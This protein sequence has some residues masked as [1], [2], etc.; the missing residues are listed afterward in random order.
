MK[1]MGTMN[2]I[3]LEK[4]RL[5]AEILNNRSTIPPEKIEEDSRIIMSKLFA[6]PAYTQS[7]TIMCFIDLKK[8]VIT[9]DFIRRSMDNGKRV[10]VPIIV[11]EES[12]GRSMRAS[13]LLDFEDDLES[14]TMGILEPKPDKRRYADPAEIDFIV[15]PGLAFDI[16]R[17][18]LGYGAGFYDAYLKKIRPDCETVAVCFDY[19]V[20][21]RIPV[22]DYDVQVGKIITELRTI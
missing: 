18:R 13:Q 2:G 17:N 5:R 12:G 9:R 14:G 16:N 15:V 7:K 6:L 20:F 4:K 19:Q 10:L 22:K 11:K 8:E 21:E 3:L 1:T